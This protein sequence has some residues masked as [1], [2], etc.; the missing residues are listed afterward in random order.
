MDSLEVL[1]LLEAIATRT[2][3]PVSEIVSKDRHA[4]IVKARDQAARE[5]RAR[6]LSLNE[7]GRALG[8]RDHK[9]ILHSLRK[10]QAA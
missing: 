4:P 3:V 6:G 5:L 7:I 1:S 10:G 9:T 8:G 2:G